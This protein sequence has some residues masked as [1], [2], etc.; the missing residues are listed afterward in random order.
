MMIMK[1]ELFANG[2]PNSGKLI[3]YDG[4]WQAKTMLLNQILFVFMLLDVELIGF[5]W[6]LL[7]LDKRILRRSNDR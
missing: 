4:G 5:A 3:F 7:Y 6:F 2:L 1:K